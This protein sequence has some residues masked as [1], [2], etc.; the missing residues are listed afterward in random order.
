MNATVQMMHVSSPLLQSNCRWQ[1]VSNRSVTLEPTH[2]LLLHE[3]ERVALQKLALQKLNKSGLSATIRIPKDSNP[4]DVKGKKRGYL[5][6]KRVLRKEKGEK[7]SRA[8]IKERRKLRRISFLPRAP[9][10]LRQP[11]AKGTPPRPSSECPWVN[12]C[13]GNSNNSC[14]LSWIA[15]DQRWPVAAAM[16]ISR[17]RRRLNNASATVGPARDRSSRKG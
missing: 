5:L 7:T 9:Q 8:L 4:K 13:R 16:L 2:L 12:A 3:F 17:R 6:K 1:H 11:S 15:N 14:C 10:M